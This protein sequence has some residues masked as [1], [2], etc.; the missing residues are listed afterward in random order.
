M[1]KFTVVT[2]VEDDGFNKY[3][4]EKIT[5]LCA[6]Y[7][8]TG[9]LTGVNRDF[10]TLENPAIVYETGAW[11]KKGY[12]DVQALPTNELRIRTAAIESYGILK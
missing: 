9:T 7:F 4:G 3:A 12:T 6:N 11:D 5:V 1:K 2:E 8:Y 10:I